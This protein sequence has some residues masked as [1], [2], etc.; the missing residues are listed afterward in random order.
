MTDSPEN[1]TIRLLQ[2]MRS[3]MRELRTDLTQRIDGNTVLLNLIAGVTHDHEQ[4]LNSL[5]GKAK[6]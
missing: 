5:E 1:H 4:R 3:E 2:E 6:P